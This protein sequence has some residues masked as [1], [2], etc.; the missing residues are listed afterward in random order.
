MEVKGRRGVALLAAVCTLTLLTASRVEAQTKPGSIKNPPEATIRRA[1]PTTF[2]LEAT[3]TEPDSPVGREARL[4][5]V[6][7]ETPG[8]IFNPANRDPQHPEGQPEKVELRSYRSV[9]TEPP[10]PATPFPPFVAPTIRVFP[11]ET[12][13]ITLENQ[14]PPEPGCNS[15]DINVPH[16]FNTTNLHAHGVWVSPVGN[17]DNVL[18]TIRPGVTFDYEYNIPADHPAGTFWY[19][20]HRHGSTAMQVGSGMA[21]ALIIQG[22]R[23]PSKDASGDLDTLL[24][25]PDGTPFRERVLLF[26]QIAYACRDAEGEIKKNANGWICDQVA[27][28]VG[29][30]D[31]HRDIFQVASTWASSGRHTTINGR[32]TEPFDEPAIAGQL[33]R[34]RMVHGGVRATLGVSIRKRRPDAQPYDASSAAA[35]AVDQRQLQRLR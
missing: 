34:W 33:E 27:G 11:G 14:L 1:A 4:T 16:C 35:E 32:T 12:V 3:T 28:D 20:P 24:R 31:Q 5:L 26:Q 8:T 29:Q 22:K 18:L 13:R 10:D 17:S 23:L 15:A 21:G 7:D 25:T 9:P 30:V 19:H 6:I 2:G